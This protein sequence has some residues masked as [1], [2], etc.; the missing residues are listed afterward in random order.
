MQ[1]YDSASRQAEMAALVGTVSPFGSDSEMMDSFI[2]ANRIEDADKMKA[3]YVELINVLTA[4]YNPKPSEIVQRY[5]FNSWTQKNGETVADCSWVKKSQHSTMSTVP[6]CHKCCETD[7][8]V[9]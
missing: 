5:K 9:E 4:H 7:P 8:C 2:Q 6:H 3:V 1:D